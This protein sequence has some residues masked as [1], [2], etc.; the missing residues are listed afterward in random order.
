M[1]DLWKKWGW[2]W[3]SQSNLVLSNVILLISFS[4]GMSI[5]HNESV[6]LHY[7]LLYTFQ[8]CEVAKTG[9]ERNGKYSTRISFEKRH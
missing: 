1:W 9:A 8:L 7:E 4:S 6:S 3:F 2:G 5:I